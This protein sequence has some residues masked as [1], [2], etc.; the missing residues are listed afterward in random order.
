MLANDLLGLDGSSIANDLILQGLSPK[1]S[2]QAIARRPGLRRSSAVMA[3][4]EP[5]QEQR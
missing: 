2:L 1:A 3:Q 4:S 5:L